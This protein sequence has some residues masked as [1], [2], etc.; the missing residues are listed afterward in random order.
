MN[1][2]VTLRA[3]RAIV[4]VQPAVGLVQDPPA[5][6]DSATLET[7]RSSICQRLQAA[8]SEPPTTPFD[9][10]LEAETAQPEHSC[11]QGVG[12]LANGGR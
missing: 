8:Q 11:G 4:D 10:V 3:G 6:I 1:F 2:I 12:G 7:G 5:T 9:C